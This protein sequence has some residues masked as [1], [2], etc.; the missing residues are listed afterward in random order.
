A[1]IAHEINTPMQFVGG[2]LSFL[3]EGFDDLLKL[4]NHYHKFR[5]IVDQEKIFPATCEE[6]AELEEEIDIDY[7]TEEMPTAFEQTQEGVDRVIKLVQG[8]KGFAHSDRDRAKQ[9]MDINTIIEN[10]LIVSQN[11]YKYVADIETNLNTLPRIM[12]YP[13]DIGQVILNLIVN[14]AHAISDITGESG[15]K[16]CIR[17]ETCHQGDKIAITVADTGTGIPDSIKNRIFDPFFTTK[18]VGRGSGQGLAIARTI[19]HDQHQGT[20]SYTSTPGQGTTFSIHL[21]AESPDKSKKPTPQ[22][23]PPTNKDS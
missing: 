4:I 22:E 23:D 5:K 11:E 12:V 10:T 15:K 1:G 3:R 9:A 18:E 8:L 19:I 13:G 14:A 21:P 17:I 16:G 7:L 6:L 20:L 2:N